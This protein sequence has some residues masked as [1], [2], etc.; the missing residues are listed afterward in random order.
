LLPFLAV[1]FG[2]ARYLVPGLP[3]LLAGLASSGVTAW[4]GWRW[5]RLGPALAVLLLMGIL[6]VPGT[7]DY[8]EWNRTRWRALNDL[9]ADGSVTPAQV[10]GGFEFNGLHFYNPAY[11]VQPDKSWWWVQKDDYVL[12]FGPM[13]NR[14]ILKEYY[15]SRWLPPSQARIVVLGKKPTAAQ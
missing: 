7:H 4:Q 5:S 6:A 13:E 10:D 3:L 1:G 12:A 2:S 9:L 14:P 8:L 11:K 15:F